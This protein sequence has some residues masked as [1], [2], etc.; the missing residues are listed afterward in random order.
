MI[1]WYLIEKSL[2][3]KL[4]V[5]EQQELTAWLR[6]SFSHQQLYEKIQNKKEYFLTDVQ[7]KK[8][9]KHFAK[10]LIHLSRHSWKYRLLKAGSIAAAVLLLIAGIYWSYQPQSSPPVKYVAYHTPD[11]TN[12][13]LITAGGETIPLTALSPEDTLKIDGVI[14]AKQKKKK[15]AYLP[16]D[17][18]FTV[19]PLNSVVVPRGAEFQLTLSD[20]T[21]VW[22]N[23]DS[24]IDFPVA[25]NGSQREVTLRG[26]AYFKVSPDTEKPFIVHCDGM[27]IR[28][29]GTEFNINTRKKTNLQTTLVKGEVAVTSDSCHTL[30]LKPGEMSETNGL[31]GEINSR[32]V[33][34]RRYTAWQQGE[35]FFE[36]ASIEEILQELALWYDVVIEYQDEQVKQE[37]FSG[38]LLREETISSL[39]HKIEQ[40]TYVRFTL[41]QNR[42]ITSYGKR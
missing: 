19:S 12:V 1:D 26:E 29:L 38:C 5:T 2:S 32:N 10:K 8:W 22:L 20:H 4:T 3:G 9:R 14:I 24:K 18:L 13:H 25:F 27:D 30:I 28:V 34:I 37:K 35:Y 23:A 42:I 31:T 36:N 21:Q 41:Q 7:Y 33:N 11:R 17:T 40:T 6:Q 16:Q 39:L 15:L